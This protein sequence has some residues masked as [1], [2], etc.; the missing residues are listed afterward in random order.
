MILVG[1][2][3]SGAS[4]L[5]HHLLSPENEHVQVYEISGFASDNL[6]GA[7][8][9]AYAISRGTRCRQ[10]LFSLSLNPPDGVAVS[11][12]DFERAV[13]QA[14]ERLGLS[15][16]PRAIVFHEKEGRRHCH[17]VWS[18]ID[19]QSMKAIQLSYSKRKLQDLSRALYLEHDWTMP[20]GLENPALRDPTNFTLAEWQQAKR[21]DIDPREIKNAIQNCWAVS[22]GKATFEHA[23]QERGFLLARGDRC[24]FVAVDYQGGVYSLT[25]SLNLK[26]RDIAARLGDPSTLKSVADT[27]HLIAARMT[28]ALKNHIHQARQSF[29]H[30]AATFDRAK[31]DMTER[32]RDARVN[33]KSAHEQREITAARE[34]A[35]RFRNGLR[36][37]WDRVSGHHVKIKR[38]NEAEAIAAKARDRAERHALVTRQLLERQTLQA[39]IKASRKRQA[40]LLHELRSDV[41]R[42]L[43]M[44]REPPDVPMETRRRR[45][46]ARSMSP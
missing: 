26:S 45:R 2:Q 11:D 39:K 1:N 9:E 12:Q 43:I 27:K 10:Y 18:R 46:R 38:G 15:N 28:P 44:G 37:L 40:G 36:G 3:R 22:D 35:K 41:T 16:Q 17:A 5:A 8:N 21:V 24:G 14:G 6:H 7:F 4:N 29:K 30:S 34:R 31:G 25:R 42:Y 32:H 19:G 20:R 23:L 13:N 33:L